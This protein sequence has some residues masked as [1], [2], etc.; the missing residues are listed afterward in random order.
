MLVRDSLTDI[1][2]ARAAG[3][4]G[5]AVIGYA[6]KAWKVDAFGSADIVVTSMGEIAQALSPVSP[7]SPRSA[8]LAAP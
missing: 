4:A 6:N 2:A 3:A 1:E 8:R 5:A 7:Q